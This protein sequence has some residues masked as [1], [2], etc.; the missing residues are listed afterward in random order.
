WGPLYD[1]GNGLA[2]TVGKPQ[3]I[4][5]SGNVVVGKRPI[6]GRS[7]DDLMDADL[8]R[9]ASTGALGIASVGRLGKTW[10]M[11][12]GGKAV[13]GISFEVEALRLYNVRSGATVFESTQALK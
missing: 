3:K 10:N 13:K 7:P 4:S 12:G 9:L 11:S 1:V 2:L 6:D 5:D 8:R